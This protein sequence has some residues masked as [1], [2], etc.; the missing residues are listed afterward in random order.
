MF[1][2]DNDVV[3]FGVDNTTIA[4]GRGRPS[5]RLFSDKLYNHGLVVADIAHMPGSVCGTWNAL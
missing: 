4:T 2:I 5:V 3:I 1:R